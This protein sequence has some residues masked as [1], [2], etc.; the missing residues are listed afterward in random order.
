MLRMGYYSWL[1]CASARARPP[2][3]PYT[4]GEI[5]GR[6]DASQQTVGIQCMIVK[7]R[8]IYKA[9]AETFEWWSW[10]LVIITKQIKE[11]NK[12]AA[13]RAKIR[14]NVAAKSDGAVLEYK[15]ET[16]CV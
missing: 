9:V 12:I 5:N 16:K 6:Y 11:S 10:S 14:P 3:V 1:V 4:T 7:N 15:F 2:H 13:A 8:C